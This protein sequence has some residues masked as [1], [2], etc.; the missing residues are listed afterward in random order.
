M[1]GWQREGLSNPLAPSDKEPVEN[2]WNQQ[3]W[4]NLLSVTTAAAAQVSLWQAAKETIIFSFYFLSCLAFEKRRVAVTSSSRLIAS[5]R[6]LPI[7]RPAE[8][9]IHRCLT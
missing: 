8:N 4:M 7:L 3:D 9:L 2:I 6:H 1:M 5:L